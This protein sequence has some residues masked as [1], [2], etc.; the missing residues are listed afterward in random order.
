MLPEGGTR[1]VGFAEGS[2]G[3]KHLCRHCPVVPVYEGRF[4]VVPVEVVMADIAQQVAAGA[5]HISFGDPD[6]FNGP[7]HGMRLARALHEAFPQVSFDATIK[8]QHLID[9][10]GG[11]PYVTLK[12]RLG[13]SAMAAA[14]N[15]MLVEAPR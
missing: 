14:V 7:T 10:A 2:R 15:A 12:G 6:F 4:R 3:C 11:V 13:G 8:I 9:H 5:T 1:A